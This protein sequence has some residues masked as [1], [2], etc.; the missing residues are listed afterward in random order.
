MANCHQT[1]PKYSKIK[2]YNFPS[3][4]K[5]DWP[6]KWN[7][8]QCLWLQH[9]A[10]SL[11]RSWCSHWWQLFLLMIYRSLIWPYLTYGICVWGQASKFL[12][13]KLLTLQ[14][15]VFRLTFFTSRDEHAIPLFVKPTILPVTMTYFETIANLMH[16]IS[17]G[18][19]PLPFR[20]LFIKSNEAHWY[21]TR[22]R[23]KGNFFQK[24]VKLEI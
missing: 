13:N 1:E 10:I 21:N 3:A 8:Y 16:D 19:A 6:W 23:E 5:E 18:S 4:P 14:K 24:D 12:I 17:H 2:L 7:C 11:F 15:R 22:S 20:A 9:W